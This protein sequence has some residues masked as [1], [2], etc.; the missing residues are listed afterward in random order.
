[1]KTKI[2]LNDVFD[3]AKNLYESKE[4]TLNDFKSGLFLLK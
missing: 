4:L 1:M 2:K 3:C